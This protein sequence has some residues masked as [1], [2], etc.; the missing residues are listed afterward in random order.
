[1]VQGA[2]G[3]MRSCNFIK[4][5]CSYNKMKLNEFGRSLS[6]SLLGQQCNNEPLNGRTF[7]SSKVLLKANKSSQRLHYRVMHMSHVHSHWPT[8]H[9]CIC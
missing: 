6:W 1:M 8:Y 9:V 2:K 5:V 4:G 7:G 3:Y